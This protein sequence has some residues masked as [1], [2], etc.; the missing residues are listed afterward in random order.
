MYCKAALNQTT[1]RLRHKIDLHSS[2]K[3]NDQK[4]R[5]T[6]KLFTRMNQNLLRYVWKKTSRIQLSRKNAL[7]E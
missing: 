2:V 4:T 6:K 5:V 3:A 7:N 1:V